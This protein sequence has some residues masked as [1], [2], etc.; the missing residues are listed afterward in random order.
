M[1]LRN[2]NHCHD[3]SLRL[4]ARPT[5]LTEGPAGATAPRNFRA[6]NVTL[7]LHYEF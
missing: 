6:N 5:G 4:F 7:G 1:Q 3:L 2:V